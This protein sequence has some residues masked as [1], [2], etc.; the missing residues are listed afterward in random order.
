MLNGPLAAGGGPN[1]V[2]AN[3]V[4]TNCGVDGFR[5]ATNTTAANIAAAH[6]G[7]S[8]IAVFNSGDLF[9]GLALAFA[10][11]PGISSPTAA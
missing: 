9:T 5:I 10:R 2:V 3:A 7:D 11:L 8:G 6:N 1:A 4:S